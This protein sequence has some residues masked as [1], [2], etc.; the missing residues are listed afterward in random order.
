[1]AKNSFIESTYFAGTKHWNCL[2]EAIPM[3]AYNIATEISKTNL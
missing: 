1:M 2:Y 3:Y